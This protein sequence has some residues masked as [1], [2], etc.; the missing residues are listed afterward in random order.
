MSVHRFIFMT[1]LLLVFAGSAAAQQIGFRIGGG[2][3]SHYSDSRPV[4]AFKLGVG[5]EVEFDQH[6]TLTPS[7]LFAARGWKDP[8]RT[9][10]V[11]DDDGEPVLDE[12]GRPVT[13]VMSRSATANYLELP[14][15]LSYYLRL[16]PSRYIVLSTGPYAAVGITGKA[17]TKGDGERA[18]SEKFFYE[19]KTFDEP[20]T[21]RFDAGWQVHA[22]Y[23][24]PSGLTVGVE[25]DFGLLRF[26]AAGARN[27]AGLLTLAYRLGR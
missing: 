7:L 21:H 19:G 1:V 25:A 2:L 3:A 4:G 10:A 8:D 14:V 16:G 15:L 9:V 26:N 11:L 6:W 27:V 5:C 13:G 24:F 17:R 22:G 18:G 23:Q 20:G 12:E